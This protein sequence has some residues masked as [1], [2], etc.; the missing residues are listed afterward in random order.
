LLT[1]I[2]EV[3]GSYMIPVP[4]PHD[5]DAQRKGVEMRKK[6]MGFL[7]EGGVVALFPSGVVASSETF[8][9]RPLRLN[10]ICS[11]QK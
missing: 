10:G 8:L 9:A 11:R 6:A 4:F 2:D 5:P 7:K 3:A 1:S